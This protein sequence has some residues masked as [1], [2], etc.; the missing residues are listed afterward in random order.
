MNWKRQNQWFILWIALV[1]LLFSCTEVEHETIR[2]V[3]AS[4]IPS[5]VINFVQP[6]PTRLESTLEPTQPS[7]FHPQDTLTAIP[8]P[9][10]PSEE[11]P[12][13]SDSIQETMPFEDFEDLKITIIFDNY[14]YD[15]RLAPSWG[16]SALVE[17]EGLD[18]LFD[19]GGSGEIFMENLHLLALDPKEIDAVILSHPHGDH[20]AGIIPL[21]SE[22]E[23]PPVYLL[24]GFSSSF[25][26]RISSQTT[27][28]EVDTAMEIYPGVFSTGG[29]YA[30]T[31]SEQAMVIDRGKDIVVI[32]G[33]AHPGVVNIVR[34][35]KAVVQSKE[36]GDDKPVALVLG[37]FHLME[38]SRMEVKSIIEDLLALG[39][40]RVSPTHCTGDSAISLF[41]ESFGTNF[42]PA[43]VGK[44]ITLP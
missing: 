42:I 39:V 40:Q 1:V 12:T 15:D 25:K 23:A 2:L 35:A 27:V 44:I 24:P 33:C 13:I 21:L 31:L 3:E 28:Y 20:I 7:L 26:N 4:D 19:T 37:G 17:F 9:F 6:S 8:S 30:N 41:Q 36:N 34:K 32:T 22:A 38:A 16:F 29:L 43:G 18:I 5:T 11:E 10:S 14:P